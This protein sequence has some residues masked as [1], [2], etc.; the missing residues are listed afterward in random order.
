MLCSTICF[1]KTVKKAVVNKVTEIVLKT[2]KEK[3]SYSIGLDIAKSLKTQKL[4]IDSNLILKGLTDGLSGKKP[5]LTEDEVKQV[6]ATMQQEMQTK[7]QAEQTKLA[8]DNKAKGEAFL[9]AN[10]AKAGVVTLPSGLQYQEITPGTGA[11]PTANDTVVVHYAGT[12]IDGK[13]FDSSYKRNEPAKFV[14]SR[15]IPGWTEALQLM[16]VGAKWKLFIPANLAYGENGAAPVI[17]PNSVLIFEVELIG[18]ETPPAPSASP[19][20]AKN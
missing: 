4:D 12:L 3:L 10:K 15:V 9:V 5:L 11:T 2:Q 6:F 14:A 7:Y 1:G 20:A 16:K 18:I 13:E 8:T 19:D 17:E